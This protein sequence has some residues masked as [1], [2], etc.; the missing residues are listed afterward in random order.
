MKKMAYELNCT[1]N[2]I[3]TCK[4]RKKSFVS[5]QKQDSECYKKSKEVS[6]FI[7]LLSQSESEVAKRLVL[8]VKSAKAY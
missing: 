1:V 5:R 4:N 3:Y 2:R 7:L 6:E 8:S